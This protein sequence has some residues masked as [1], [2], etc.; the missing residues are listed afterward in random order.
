MAITPGT[1]AGRYEIA[2]LIRAGR[3]GEVYRAKDPKLGRDVA[4]KVLPA[5]FS[6]DKDRL[7]RFE[8]EAQA[9][10]QLVELSSI[11]LRTGS[12]WPCRSISL[13]RFPPERHSRCLK[14]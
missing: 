4:I 3:M 5:A 9:A 8:Q 14:S 10:A 12:S 1:H 6:A 2:S 13:Q 11:S 7:A